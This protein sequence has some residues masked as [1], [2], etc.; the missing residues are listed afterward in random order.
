MKS[1]QHASLALALLLI[2]N[3]G[4]F[5]GVAKERNPP[6]DER[7][8]K[9][10]GPTIAGPSVKLDTMGAAKTALTIGGVV[11]SGGWGALATP[12]LSAGDDPN[13]CATARAGGKQAATQERASE[14]KTR[15]DDV[16]RS[17]RDLF[18]R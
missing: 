12:L 17:L 3:S 18:K 8:L 2:G 13:P 14:P 1:R 4:A 16:V 6:I 11:A 15:Q 5:A 7:A 10:S 9:G